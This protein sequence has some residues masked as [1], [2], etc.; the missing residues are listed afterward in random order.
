VSFNEDPSPPPV[1]SRNESSVAIDWSDMSGPPSPSPHRVVEVSS[2]W[3]PESATRE[4]G[5]GSKSL[6]GACPTRQDQRV[7]HSHTALGGPHASEGRRDPHVGMI[8]PSSR[9]STSPLPV[10]STTIPTARMQIP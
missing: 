8:R 2:S 7:T 3:R 10:I 9:R 1:W 4:K 6:S 5:A